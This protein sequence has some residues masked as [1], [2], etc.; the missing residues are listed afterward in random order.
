MRALYETIMNK[1][2]KIDIVVNTAGV[3]YFTLTKNGFWDEWEQTVDVNCKGTGSMMHVKHHAT[4]GTGSE[5]Y[6]RRITMNR[7]RKLMKK[8]GLNKF[9]QAIVDGKELFTEGNPI[10]L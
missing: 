8:H 4:G 10:A 5:K 1:Y 9:A 3:M 7:R 6:L 2:G